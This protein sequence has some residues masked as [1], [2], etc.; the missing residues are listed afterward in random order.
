MK[1]ETIRKIICIIFSFLLSVVAFALAAGLVFRSTLLDKDF[2]IREL[3][4]SG[5]SGILQQEI[6]SE[7]S[8]YGYMAG[9]DEEFFGRVLTPQEINAPVISAVESIYSGKEY[10]AISEDE[11]S[12][13]LYDV[14]VAD[15]QARGEEFSEELTASLEQLA[16]SCADFAKEY[17]RLPFISVMR[18]LIVNAESLMKYILV[19]CGV[20]A[21][22]CV[23]LLFFVNPKKRYLLKYLSHALGASALMGL[24]PC[25][26]VLATGIL[27]K[28]SIEDRA[29]YSLFQTCADD[30]V[31]T[32]I[33]VFAAFLIASVLSA[34]LF[35]KLEKKSADSE[36]Q[37]VPFDK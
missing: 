8:E 1:K 4:K 21:V 36:A 33:T 31:F 2:F 14:F 26:I 17:A 32:V 6:V 29:L 28:I 37:Y 30:I 25:I 20:F 15:L 3:E 22:F 9:F 7:L 13:R 19:F 35:V 16:K 23:A 27:K 24:V 10:V 12:Q 11:L 5:Y 34:V 18:S